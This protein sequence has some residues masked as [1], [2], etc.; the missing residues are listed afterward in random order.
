[1][2]VIVVMRLLMFL[3]AICCG[4]KQTIKMDT[5]IEVRDL[6]STQTRTPFQLLRGPD[7]RTRLSQGTVK[8]LKAPE[9]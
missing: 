9:A 6:S 5:F 4:K 1:M 8:A 7:I 3:I 2:T